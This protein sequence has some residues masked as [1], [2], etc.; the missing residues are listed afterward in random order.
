[1]SFWKMSRHR[2]RPEIVHL[3]TSNLSFE[4]ACEGSNLVRLGC[5]RDQKLDKKQVNVALDAGAGEAMPPFHNVHNGNTLAP[6]MAVANLKR[7]RERLKPNGI[8][9]MGDMSA[10]DGEVALMLGEYGLD[11]VGAVKMT[12]KARGLAKKAVGYGPPRR[13]R[14]LRLLVHER[15][16]ALVHQGEG[17]RG[18]RRRG[19]GRPHTALRRQQDGDESLRQGE[20][21]SERE[22]RARRGPYLPPRGEKD[23]PRLL[24][25]PEDGAPAGDEGECRGV[26]QG[27][28]A[29]RWRGGPVLLRHEHEI[30]GAQEDAPDPGDALADRGFPSRREAE[31]R[32]GGL[33]GEED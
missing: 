31:P 32:A 33:P 25:L 17:G 5:S 3:N 18:Q 4:G 27:R 7:I 15:G 20:D 24:R 9:V 28:E 23:V 10:V 2:I 6:T 1:M 14:R 12:E 26:L 19:G 30:L 13:R 22:L 11:F 8:M 16:A 29:R 21:D